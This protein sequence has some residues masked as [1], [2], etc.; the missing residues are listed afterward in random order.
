MSLVGIADKLSFSP[1]IMNADSSGSSRESSGVEGC[2]MPS[3]SQQ[4]GAYFI[5]FSE[6]LY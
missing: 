3:R 1:Y 5:L 6:G 4:A 2:R